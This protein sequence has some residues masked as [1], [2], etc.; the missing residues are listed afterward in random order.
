MW[1]AIC[2]NVNGPG[3]Y[4]A[5]WSQAEKDKYCMISLTC[6]ILKKYNKLVDVTKKKQTHRN[7]KQISVY[8]WG[9]QRGEGQHGARGLKV[10]TTRYQI[11]CKDI[12]YN[13]GN[14]GNIL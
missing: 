6:E 2:N 12:L 8:Q 1:S 7:K 5:K 13:T 3:G 4:G 11:T 9:E 14:I 10:Q